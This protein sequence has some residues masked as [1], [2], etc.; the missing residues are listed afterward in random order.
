M[1]FNSS[2]GLSLCDVSGSL[3]INEP[4]I[5]IEALVSTDDTGSINHPI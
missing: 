4:L 5:V 1:T 3:A 2:K